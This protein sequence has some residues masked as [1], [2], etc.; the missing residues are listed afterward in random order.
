MQAPPG[1][2]GPHTIPQ[3]NPGNVMQAMQKLAVAAKMVG[4]A[5]PMIPIGEEI[6]T[7]VMKVNS[8]LVK[9]LGEAKDQMNQIQTL[10]QQIKAAQQHAAGPAG[11]QQAMPP[12][13]GS[14][15]GPAMPPPGG[16]PPGM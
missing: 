1:N 14:P 2:V 15:S 3:S 10:M 12:P 5:L 16:A 8:D 9:I 4:E 6:H 11:L 13:G 7:K